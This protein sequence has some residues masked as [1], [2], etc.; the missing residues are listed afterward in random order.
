MYCLIEY[1]SDEIPVRH[2]PEY[3][4]GS[5]EVVKQFVK[6]VKF[7]PRPKLMPGSPYNIEPQVEHC[8]RVI[9]NKPLHKSLSSR[10]VRWMLN[11]KYAEKF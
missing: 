6:D 11:S 2:S 8:C 5:K 1:P 7:R 9:A 3:L 4:F 10:L